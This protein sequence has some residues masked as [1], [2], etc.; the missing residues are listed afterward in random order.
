M[1]IGEAGPLL[2]FAAE[3]VK[4]LDP[5]LAHAIAEARES[6]QNKTW[7][8][9]MSRKFWAAF[10]QLCALI[11][12][13]TMDCISAKHKNTSVFSWTKLR[14]TDVSLAEKTSRRYL[15]ALSFFIP[16]ALLLQLY[17]WYGPNESKKISATLTNTQQT[18]DAL[19]T[20]YL[21]LIAPGAHAAARTH[22]GKPVEDER[23]L[24]EK[25]RLNLLGLRAGLDLLD[26]QTRVLAQT[27]LRFFDYDEDP[28]TGQKLKPEG[29]T[30]APVPASS[31]EELL[32]KF[33]PETM[34][35]Y[36]AVRTTAISI[37]EEAGQ[38]VSVVLSFALP[39]IFGLIGAI[40]YVIRDIS[41]QISNS[42]FSRT[43]PLRH[44]MRTT[45]GAIA[46]ITVGFFTHLPDQL[47]LTPLALAFLA[48][49]GV[50]SIFSMFDG[51]I[52]KFKHPGMPEGEP[53]AA[54]HLRGSRI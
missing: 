6:M 15:W 7:N 11:H 18:Y 47:A 54:A 51:I 35:R 38:R 8:P 30:A 12:P 1:A 45:L 2:R 10:N 24:T 44:V 4:D 9:E 43:S 49:Y 39:L 28:F 13:T 42:T 36:Y 26:H 37:Q 31:R 53:P 46:G 48:G 23:Q 40:A 14:R 17:V 5:A 20:G 25:F 34:T 3:K 16:L 29:T 41:N 33:Y 32:N 22:T 27:N 19:N 21:S 50:E 52:A